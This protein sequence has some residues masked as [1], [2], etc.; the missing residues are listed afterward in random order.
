MVPATL[1]AIAVGTMELHV[2]IR[3]YGL[4]RVDH[5]HGR[6]PPRAHGGAHP[7][8]TRTPSSFTLRPPLT[9]AMTVRAL[10]DRAAGHGG[11][12]EAMA[13]SPTGRA[14]AWTCGTSADM[15]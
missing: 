14:L 15:Q 1:R 3:P 8:S 9:P 5:G 11:V 12:Y 6:Y 7:R 4:V 2:P 10:R 13:L